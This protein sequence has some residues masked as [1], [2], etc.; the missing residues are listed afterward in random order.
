MIC[1]V[2]L[3]AALELKS[4]SPETEITMLRTTI[5]L[6]LLSLFCAPITRAQQSETLHMKWGLPGSAAGQQSAGLLEAISR[7]D[8]SYSAKF[9]SASFAPSFR[10]S[11]PIKEH[12]ELLAQLHHELPG[13]KVLG[14]RKRPG[15]EVTLIV[16]SSELR[17]R[18]DL[19]LESAE[20]YRITGL[21]ID[22]D[23]P[24]IALGSL[25]D[26]EAYLQARSVAG[27]FS[28]AVLIAR[29]WSPIFQKAYGQA[30]L[31]EPRPNKISTR[32]NLGSINKMFTGVAV[33]QLVQKGRIGLDDALSKYCPE[34]PKEVGDKVTIRYLL[35]HKSGW[36]AYWENEYYLKNFN[37]LRKLSDYIAFLKDIPLDF[38][39]GT[40]RQYSNIGYEILGAVVEKASGQD[41]YEYVRKN[42]YEAAGMNA[43]G[44]YAI[45]ELDQN[46][47][48]GYTK[49]NSEGQKQGLSVNTQSKPPKGTAA[50]GGYSTLEDL[51]KF[52]K[53]LNDFK[54]LSPRYTYMV[55]NRYQE[56][57]DPP[58]SLT[59]S[60]GYA[61]GAPGI[62]AVV[63]VDFGKGD[64]VIVLS[65]YDPPSAEEAGSAIFR[66]VGSFE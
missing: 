7:G 65:N 45:E 23:R 9:V 54:L 24:S 42:I 32:F 1:N 8:S 18:F 46:F 50:G 27:S 33:M 62:S 48:L 15:N 60:I 61:G 28:G 2:P 21:G 31:K 57:K 12:V 30:D 11:R 4:H 5:T 14:V 34:F 47:A 58:S 29:D 44:S 41:Y 49:E 38:E 36:G 63:E 17:F 6:L 43:S 37:K 35:E 56:P 3:I 66:N 53:A 64:L 40:S 20:P 51:L 19:Q 55:V 52:N 25:K 39:P 10:D 59:G 13:L 22:E 26:V 16:G